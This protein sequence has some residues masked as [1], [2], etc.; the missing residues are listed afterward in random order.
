MTHL[1][2]TISPAPRGPRA[3]DGCGHCGRRFPSARGTSGRRLTNADTT[4]LRNP[5][6][7]VR[8]G[9]NILATNPSFATI[10]PI[11]YTRVPVGQTD[12]G[13]TPSQWSGR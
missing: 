2:A 7:I 8:G 11:S 13:I 5:R 6:P 1:A 9:E 4:V 3:N 10:V 12:R